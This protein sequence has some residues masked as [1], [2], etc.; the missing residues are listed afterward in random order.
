MER[1]NQ[2]R[3][4]KRLAVSFGTDQLSAIGFTDDLTSKSLFIKTSKVFA[5]GTFLKIEVTL[6]DDQKVFLTG[7][8]VWAKKVP[9]NMIRC[10]KKS[11]MGITLFEVSEAYIQFIASLGRSSSKPRNFLKPHA[12]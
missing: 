11:G 10:F 3:I 8:V 2:K 5:P 7:K 9:P 6:P 1:R 4:S 12:S